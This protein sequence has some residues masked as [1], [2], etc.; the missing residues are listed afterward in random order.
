MILTMIIIMG[1]CLISGFTYMAVSYIKEYLE[2]RKTE[3]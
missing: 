2:D 3:Y 1:V